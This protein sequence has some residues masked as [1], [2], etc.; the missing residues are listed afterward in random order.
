MAASKD[1]LIQI[2]IGIG[3]KSQDF[4]V[5]T[6]NESDLVVEQRIVDVKYY[7]GASEE[8][9]KKTYRAKIWLDD[10]QKQVTYQEILKDK[11]IS[12]GI[13]PTPKLEIEKTFFK[14]KVL[15]K[16]EKAISFGFRKPFDPGSFGKVYDYSFDIEKVRG[17]IRQAVQNSGWKFSQVVL[18]K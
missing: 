15:F 9:L 8:K 18:G 11:T 7:G 6:S 17:P 13:L 16:K 1:D 5:K 14:G 2:L 4:D 3:K 12:M 10:I